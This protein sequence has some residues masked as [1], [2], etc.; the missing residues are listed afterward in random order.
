MVKEN[1][2]IA[3]LNI[4]VKKAAS[5]LKHHSTEQHAP[6]DNF[7]AAMAVANAKA[8]QGERRAYTVAP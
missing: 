6:E 4:N 5:K 2:Q 3:S 8:A 7:E 1:N